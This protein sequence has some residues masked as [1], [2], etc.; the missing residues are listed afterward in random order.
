[1]VEIHNDSDDLDTIPRADTMS[2][3]AVS[4]GSTVVLVTDDL[5]QIPGEKDTV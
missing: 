1:M 3:K 4:C 2:E 5:I